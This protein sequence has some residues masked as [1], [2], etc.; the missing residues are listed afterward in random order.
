[1]ISVP[2]K[3]EILDTA[4]NTHGKNLNLKAKIGAIYLQVKECPRVWHR[5]P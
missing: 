3:R 1:M 2:I 4:T 5:D